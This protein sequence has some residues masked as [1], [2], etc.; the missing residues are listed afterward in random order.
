MIFPGMMRR[1]PR[2]CVEGFGVRVREAECQWCA[3][4]EADGCGGRAIS[5]AGAGDRQAV[6]DAGGRRVHDLGDVGRW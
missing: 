5:G 3:G 6:F 2:E 1:C 4:I